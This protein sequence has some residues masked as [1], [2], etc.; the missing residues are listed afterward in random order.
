MRQIKHFLS[1]VLFAVASC[2]LHQAQAAEIVVDNLDTT[3]YDGGFN[4][5][6]SYNMVAVQFTTGDTG[7]ARVWKLHNILV[8]VEHANVDGYYALLKIRLHEDDNGKPGSVLESFSPSELDDGQVIVRVNSSKTPTMQPN[9]NYWVSVHYQGLGEFYWRQG[10]ELNSDPAATGEITGLT[11]ESLD[12]GSTWETYTRYL[13]T[14]FKVNANLNQTRKITVTATDQSKVY[15]D[16]LTLDNTAFT[17]KDIDGDDELP[18]GETITS[19]TISS[20]SGMDAS[21]T[22]SAGTYVNDIVISGATG[23]NGF[24]VSNYSITYQ[25]GDLIVEPY[26]ITVTADQ[27]EKDFGTVLTLDD[28]AF[29]VVGEDTV[30]FDGSSVTV[31]PG[32]STLP[33][34]ETIDAVTLSSV[35]GIADSVTAVAGVYVDEISIVGVV[36]SNGFV[37]SNYDITY[38][39]GDLV[40]NAV[41]NTTP[42]MTIG[43]DSV[44]REATISI[45]TQIGYTYTVYTS[46]NLETDS[47]TQ[48]DQVIGDGN[49]YEYTDTDPRDTDE[50]RFYKAVRTVTDA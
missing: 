1:A 42:M 32:S 12:N 22:A 4:F 26:P 29:T 41:G 25:K 21:T 7:A 39:S 47:W 8:N 40:V 23:A 16:T 2:S 17:V 48:V 38:V 34:D 30:I 18:D 36:G 10:D 27:Q 31:I 15:G 24:D 19:V 3:Y 45:E 9:T 46:P 35:T 37:E 11:A 33:N 43:V 49:L 44:S 6:Y 20:A 28:T 5:P 13:P 14:K 50:D